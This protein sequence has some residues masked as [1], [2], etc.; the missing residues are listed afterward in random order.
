MKDIVGRISISPVNGLSLGLSGYTGR[1]E[2]ETEQI[3]VKE[4]AYGVDAEYVLNFGIHLRGEYL[5][6]R[7]KNWDVATASA[8]SGK[9]QQPRGWY[10]QT[11]CQLPPMPDLEVLARY[12]DYEKDSNTDD[13]HLKTTTLG[14]TYYLK[15]KNRITANYLIRD[16]GE[17]PIVTAQETD[18]TS[19]R[20]GN[21]FLVQAIT[22]F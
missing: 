5:A 14:M 22:V 8:S 12:E 1:G 18:A 4:T 10:L 3:A 11:S 6:A 15:G 19:S 7:W 9:T 2:G 21:L 16:A 17:S 20:I 13:S